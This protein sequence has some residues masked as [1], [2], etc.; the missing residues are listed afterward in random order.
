MKSIGLFCGFSHES[1]GS[2]AAKPEGRHVFS[3]MTRPKWF[4]N[5]AG[6]L[7]CAQHLSCVH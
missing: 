7:G 6:F 2:Y 5:F 4:D 1:N 3:H